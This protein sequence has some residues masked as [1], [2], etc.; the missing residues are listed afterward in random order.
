MLHN[1][2]LS[3]NIVK[4]NSVTIDDVNSVGYRVMLDASRGWEEQCRQN[5]TNFMATKF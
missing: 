4:Q 3:T 2:A 1:F 5:K